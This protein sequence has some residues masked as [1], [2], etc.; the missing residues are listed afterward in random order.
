MSD[1]DD[2]FAAAAG[3]NTPNDTN[4]NTLDND[5][6]TPTPFQLCDNISSD[7][8][9]KKKRKSKN[10]EIER[11][12]K[13]RSVDS[14]YNKSQSF[15]FQK[16]LQSRM[17]QIEEQISS[18]PSWL[19]LGPSFCKNVGSPYFSA[20]DYGSGNSKASLSP[21]FHISKSS[22]DNPILECFSHIRN[23]R[24]CCSCIYEIIATEY[25]NCEDCEYM[26]ITSEKSKKKHQRNVSIIVELVKYCK[27]RKN[28]KAITSAILELISVGE[29]T[30]L[31]NKFQAISRDT[32]KLN[33]SVK[34]LQK[35]LPNGFG[36]GNSKKSFEEEFLCA[37]NGNMFDA[38]VNLIVSL[39]AAYYRLYYL[40]V[41]SQLSI[42]EDKK[43][44]DLVHIPHPTTYFGVNGLSWNVRRGEEWSKSMITK[45]EEYLSKNG[46]DCESQTTKQKNSIMKRFGISL[47][48]D[49]EGVDSRS[50]LDP[51][52]FLHHNRLGEGFLLFWS[53]KW[54]ESNQ[55]SFFSQ[56]SFR[57]KHNQIESMNHSTEDNFYLSH[58]TEAPQVLCQWRDSCRDFLC[59]LYGYATLAPN[60]LNAI[61]E[62]LMSSEKGSVCSV[63]EM[64]AGT[65]Y[66]ALLLN[67]INVKTTAF[68]IAPTNVYDAQSSQ[69]DVVNEYHGST[70]AFLEVKKGG[71]NSLK[72][73]IC[74]NKKAKSTALLL[75]YPPPLT[76]MALD[77][78]VT[79]MKA[80]G[81]TIIHIGEF[82]GLTG[83]KDFEKKLM[84]HY[85]LIRR[86]DCLQWGT[87]SSEVTI[88]QRQQRQQKQGPS[89]SLLLPCLNCDERES[90][91]QSCF[92][93][94]LRYCS[95]ECFQE[96]VIPRSIH[97]AMSLIPIFSQHPRKDC[98]SDSSHFRNLSF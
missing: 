56:S 34:E 27:D 88:W 85:R 28:V 83:S 59:N 93:R 90:S 8:R 75:C 64:G 30:I 66:L 53:T 4:N 16:F 82:K 78:L 38:L 74:S 26:N 58:E 60:T 10:N 13:I 49:H 61:K 23:L 70:A 72:Q 69:S 36:D 45:V 43:N 3:D 21:L 79:F 15:L 9:K 18:F 98:F 97:Y 63:V 51:L 7:K 95:K 92:S 12:P 1:W 67:K 32:Q 91:K 81:Q 17:D 87:D 33:S 11:N 71:A 57:Q 48:S 41:I 35:G 31:E 76:N 55:S 6:K 68:D 14:T 39:D 86:L 89:T 80:G 62:E 19:T 20:D 50:T 29:R 94:H 5:V 46:L 73:H 40:Q 96:H 47:Y 84:S 37:L 25:Y 44:G 42:S 24:C 54:I 65:G 77:M 2:L 52:S 22:I